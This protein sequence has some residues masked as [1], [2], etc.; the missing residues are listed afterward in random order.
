MTGALKSDRDHGIMHLSSNY[1]HVLG[2]VV[3][4]SL[5][6]D[7]L[8]KSPANRQEIMWA[9]Y[10]ASGA[11]AVGMLIGSESLVSGAVI[12]FAGLGVPAWMISILIDGQTQTTS[13][14]IH[15]VPLLAGL[16]FVSRLAVLPRYSAAFAWLL[17]GIPFALS[18]HFCDPASMINLSHWARWPIP[19]LVPHPWQFYVG[20][21]LTSVVLVNSVAI[22]LKLILDRAS[23]SAVSAP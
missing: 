14:L 15:V 9:C 23:D 3:L 1:S 18:W 16:Y 11:L 10:W 4:A 7:V 17:F 13:V 19:Q 12:F 21:L 5:L 2:C 6:A 8:L 20:L 22:G